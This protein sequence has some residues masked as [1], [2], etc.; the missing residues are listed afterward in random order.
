MD[1]LRRATTFWDGEHLAPRVHTWM[2][3]PL[4]REAINRRIGGERG[5]WPMDWFG[6]WVRERTF[7]RAL[8]IGCGTGALERDLIRRGIC[9]SVDAIDISVSAVVAAR[10]AAKD[11]GMGSVIRYFVADFNRMRLPR[12]AWDLILFHQSLHHVDRLERLMSEVLLA[13]EPEGLL[14]LDEYVGPSRTWWTPRRFRDVRKVYDR[15]PARH[16]LQP[17]LLLPIHAEDPSEGVRSGEILPVLDKGFDVVARRPYGGNLL[18]PIFSALDPDTPDEVIR[19][20][21][22]EEDTLLGSEGSSNYQ[23]IVARPREGAARRTALRRYAAGAIAHAVFPQRLL[24]H[25]R[26]FARRVYVA[27]DRRLRRKP[28]DHYV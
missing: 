9:R 22:E 4:V 5:Q 6:E 25:L 28:I 14:F 23:I 2:E 7:R 27:V 24:L 16:R 1:D 3:H 12:T 21:I 20:L 19:N 18:A 26:A 15:L 11:A 13:L 10:A 8:S 17:K